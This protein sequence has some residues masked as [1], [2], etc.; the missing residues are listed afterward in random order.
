MRLYIVRHGEAEHHASTDAERALTK[1]GAGEV[2]AL[3]S[4]LHASQPQPKRIV[5][6][7]LLRAWQ[8]ASMVAGIWSEYLAVET[9][10]LLVPD[11]PVEHT[12]DWLMREPNPDGSVL[13]SHMP[14]VALLTGRLI[15]APASTY[16]FG[17]ANVACLELDVVAPA[18]ARLLWL[19][20]PTG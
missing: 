6:S 20:S 2:R 16:P 8:T 18:G 7:P 10:E 13:V 11:T 19:E 1:R 17:L 5:S 15:D 14:L 4:R 3:W 9:K 12:L